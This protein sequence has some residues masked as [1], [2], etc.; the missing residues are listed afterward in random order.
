MISRKLCAPHN[1]E[2]AIGAIVED[3]TTYLNHLIVTELKISP[4]YR[5]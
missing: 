5:K 3:G 2:V 1:R 4:I